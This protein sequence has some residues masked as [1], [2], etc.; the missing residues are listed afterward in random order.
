M[1]SLHPISQRIITVS[2]I[3]GTFLI[4]SIT[5]QPCSQ[6]NISLHSQSNVDNFKNYNCTIIEGQ[7][8][9]NGADI[10]NLDSLNGLVEIGSLSINS[11]NIVNFNGLSSLKK[12]HGS[13]D[14]S[15]NPS[16]TTL[17]GLEQ[18]EE[19]AGFF[20]SSNN[21]LASLQGLNNV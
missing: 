18:L 12:I 17:S 4:Q 19:V 14:I 2:L 20:I 16:L 15:F 7:L 1:I 21:V 6:Q 9:I 3:L 10:T 5:G 8:F 13:A 11:T